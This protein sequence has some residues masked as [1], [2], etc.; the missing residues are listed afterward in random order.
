MKKISALMAVIGI[1]FATNLHAAFD[2][3]MTLSQGIYS[4]GVGGEFTAVTSGLGAFQTF[5]I[6]YNEEFVPGNTFDYNKN[7]GSVA[8]GVSGQDATDSHT[9]LTMDNVS[10]GTAWLY[11]QFRAGTLTD[12]SANNYFTSGNRQSNAGILQNAIWFL[13]GEITVDQ[14]ANRYILEAESKLGKTLAQLEVD[15]KG[16]YGVIALN[17]F[18]GSGYYTS[19]TNPS[20]VTYHVNQ[21]QL[22]I[23][24]EPTTI[25]AGALLL[26]PFG[27]GAL[28]ILR[29][30]RAA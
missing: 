21:D 16:A 7:T 11:S 14:S 17:L 20:G 12:N 9:G 23:V 24:P 13:E 30:A 18:N 15:S 10:I 22:A 29:K 27:A 26:L 3:T 8:G 1:L 6:E 25:F 19:A 5:C 2:G 4:S 28:R